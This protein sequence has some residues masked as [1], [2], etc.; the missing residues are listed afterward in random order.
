MCGRDSL[1][2]DWDSSRVLELDQTVDNWDDGPYESLLVR[3]NTIV[4]Q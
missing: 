4:A 3:G 2:Y 1:N